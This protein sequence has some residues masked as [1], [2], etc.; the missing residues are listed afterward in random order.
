MQ[1]L[2]NKIRFK[3]KEIIIFGILQKSKRITFE[4]NYSED[5]KV[6]AF[7][8]INK[9]SKEQFFNEAIENYIKKCKREEKLI[10]KC[11]GNI[12]FRNRGLKEIVYI[13]EY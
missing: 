9:I 4:L 5:S 6:E 8:I 2:I 7:C 10:R 13:D 3:L 11:F 1:K 12:D